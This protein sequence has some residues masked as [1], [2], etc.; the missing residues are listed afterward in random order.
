MGWRRQGGSCGDAGH[1][2]PETGQTSWVTEAATDRSCAKRETSC[3]SVT[4][5]QRGS[6]SKGTSQKGRTLSNPSSLLPTSCCHHFELFACQVTSPKFLAA[7]QS[8]TGFLSCGKSLPYN[9]PC[10]RAQ[11]AERSSL[12]S[13]LCKGQSRAAPS[14]GGY[15]LFL[16]QNWDPYHLV[17][18]LKLLL[19][20][21]VQI[22]KTQGKIN[23]SWQCV[24]SSVTYSG[25]FLFHGKW[26]YF[27][28]SCPGQVW[29]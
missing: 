26:F 24:T 6:G 22:I 29:G 4:C 9:W 7:H 25:P 28:L 10:Q 3:H 23:R 5:V 8:S 12:W 15:F 1:F 2:S 16:C 14:R 20:G 17:W 11:P 18:M 19:L 21:E 13:L 27:D